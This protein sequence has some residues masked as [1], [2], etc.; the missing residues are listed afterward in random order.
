MRGQEVKEP[1]ASINDAELNSVHASLFLPSVI[2]PESRDFTRTSLYCKT[3][4]ANYNVLLIKRTVITL[5]DDLKC[6][7]SLFKEQ[8]K[9]RRFRKPH[10]KED[11]ACF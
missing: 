1:I 10:H 9:N 7:H 11:N 5:L 4:A 8:E 6:P 3:A 2:F